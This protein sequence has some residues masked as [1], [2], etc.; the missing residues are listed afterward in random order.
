MYG[1]APLPQ[2]LRAQTQNLDPE[3]QQRACEYLN[4]SSMPT[5]MVVPTRRPPAP[6]PLPDP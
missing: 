4:M 2:V 6:P 1:D 3:I 5:V